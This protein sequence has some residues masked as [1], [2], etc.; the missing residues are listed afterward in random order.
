LDVS[1]PEPGTSPSSALA[2]VD[3][4]IVAAFSDTVPD[5]LK[6]NSEVYLKQVVS[7]YFKK[8]GSVADGKGIPLKVMM[9]RKF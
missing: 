5:W 6:R 3:R 1:S 7:D 4:V 2:V 9:S 8:C